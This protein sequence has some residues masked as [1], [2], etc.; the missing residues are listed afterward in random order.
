[1]KTIELYRWRVLWLGKWTTTRHVATEDEIRREHPEAQ[2]L[3]H[4]RELRRSPETDDEH[5][6]MHHHPINSRPKG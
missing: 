3:D 2:R 5:A 4:T 1:M 6:A